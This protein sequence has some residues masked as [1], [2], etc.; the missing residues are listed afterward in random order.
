MKENFKF[1][2]K[3]IFSYVL[4]LLPWTLLLTEYKFIS[5][6]I[7]LGIFIF[8]LIPFLRNKNN[9]DKLETIVVPSKIKDKKELIKNT[10]KEKWLTF[11]NIISISLL[12]IITYILILTLIPQNI[13]YYNQFYYLNIYT[14]LNDFIYILIAGIFVPLTENIL[15]RKKILELKTIKNKYIFAIINAIIIYTIQPYFVTGIFFGLISLLTSIYLIKTNN[16]KNSFICQIMINLIFCINI[17]YLSDFKIL[18]TIIFI[19]IFIITMLTNF[20]EHLKNK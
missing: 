1:T 7:Y 10:K 5:F 2:I 4:Y 14:N 16:F 20:A 13:S 15:I 8:N 9:V 3:T 18:L 12:I 19:T 17:L 6:I 11:L